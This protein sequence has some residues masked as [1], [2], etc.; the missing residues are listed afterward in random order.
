VLGLFNKIEQD[1]RHFNVMLL[2][3]Q[4]IA[5]RHYASWSMACVQKTPMNAHLFGPYIEKEAF[6]ADRSKG[7]SIVSL[8]GALSGLGLMK[9]FT[10]PVISQEPEALPFSKVSL[11][12]CDTACDTRFFESEDA[13]AEFIA[14]LKRS[15]PSFNLPF[16]IVQDS[17]ETA[18]FSVKIMVGEIPSLSFEEAMD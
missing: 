8:L 2:L 18:Q 16:V 9:R 1:K 17:K 10:A 14:A 4:E 13:A 7:S 11:E 5:E 6:R 3:V 15:N 12:V